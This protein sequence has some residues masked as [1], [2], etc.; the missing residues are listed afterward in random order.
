MEAGGGYARVM[1]ARCKGAAL[2]MHGK[3]SGPY[4]GSYMGQ[5]LMRRGKGGVPV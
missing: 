2:A 4:P 3:P 1:H 5:E